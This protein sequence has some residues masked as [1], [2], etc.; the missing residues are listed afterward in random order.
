MNNIYNISIPIIYIDEAPEV[1][2]S[3]EKALVS[4]DFTTSK[5][6]FKTAGKI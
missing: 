1:F 2:R 6:L 3:A 4:W 5:E